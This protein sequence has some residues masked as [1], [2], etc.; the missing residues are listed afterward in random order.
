LP[1]LGSLAAGFLARHIGTGP[2]LFTG[3]LVCLAAGAWLLARSKRYA[4]VI[5][6]AA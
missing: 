3:G 2:T 6:A 1:P 5:E 4:R